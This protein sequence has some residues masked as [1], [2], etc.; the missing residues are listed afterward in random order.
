MRI[1]GYDFRPGLIPTLATLALLPALIGLGLWQLDR[2][3]DKRALEADYR[4]AL[5]RPPVPLRRA[6][7]AARDQRYLPVSVRGHYDPAHQ[8]LFDNQ[9]R[10]GRVGYRVL[11]P[12]LVDGDAAAILVD[13]GWVPLGTHRSQLPAVP[14]GTDEREIRGLLAPPPAVGLILGALDGGRAGWPRVIERVELERLGD[15]L[16]REL[17]PDLALLDA[18]QADGYLREWQPPR[19]GPERHVAYAVQWFAM[20]AVLVLIYLRLNLR[21]RAKGDATAGFK[22]GTM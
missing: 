8:F 13:R 7:G 16:G 17:M 5:G 3:A 12:F 2:A 21:R 18:A 15:R 22:V 14:V 9:I 6:L 10:H 19:L 11:T 1:G 4:A 20:A